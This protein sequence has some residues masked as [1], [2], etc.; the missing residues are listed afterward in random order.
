MK[1]RL[2]KLRGRPAISLAEGSAEM[3]VARKAEIQA[4]GGEI[5]ILPEKIQ[6]SRES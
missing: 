4:Q 6:R 3:A 5:V 2:P 1:R